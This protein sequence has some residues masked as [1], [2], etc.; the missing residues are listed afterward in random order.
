[1]KVVS[2]F[3]A[4]L[5]RILHF[6]L[7]QAPPQQAVPL[8][9]SRC[10]PPPCLSRV[11]VELVEDTLA[12]GCTLFLARS[13]GWR[14]GRFVRADHV[15]GG[16]LWERTAPG[17][18]GL[19]FSRVT[20]DF[21]VW[22]TAKDPREEST[23]GKL[24]EATWLA[25][26][27]Q[28]TPADWLFFFLVYRAIKHEAELARALAGEAG[29]GNNAL[30]RLVY[31]EDFPPAALDAGLGYD[32]WTAGIGGC[33]LEALQ[34]LLAERWLAVESGK[35]RMIDWT[36][37]LALGEAQERVLD[38]FLDALERRGRLDLADFLLQATARLLSPGAAA[39]LWVSDAVRT[40]PP[41]MADRMQMQQAALALVHQVERF[42]DWERQARSVG[43]FDE[44]YQASQLTKEA[45]ERYGGDGLHA[46]AQ[47]IIQELDPLHAHGGE[48]GA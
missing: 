35:A 46:R 32:I 12:K 9:Q 6:F 7:G 10:P 45:W 28:L 17:E 11:A 37:L 5:L 42:R 3:E 16:R 30:C 15:A 34:S 40:A 36:A 8:V 26:A 39:H 33:I 25:P 21:L 24:A 31:P 27:A 22:I 44:G 20:L 13:G 41:R 18:L 38:G 23:T 14:Q 1:M 19:Q 48:P 43:Y 29:F 2:R 47:A 4:S